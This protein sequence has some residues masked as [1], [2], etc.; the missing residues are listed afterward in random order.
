MKVFTS[1]RLMCDQQ[2]FL[3]GG[4]W[5]AAS[6]ARP[7]CLFR[8][9]SI[10]AIC[11]SKGKTEGASRWGRHP[12]FFYLSLGVGRGGRARYRLQDVIHAIFLQLVHEAPQMPH[13]G[14]L[15]AVVPKEASDV[16][17]AL[18]EPNRA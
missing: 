17:Y 15:G 4:G 6:R 11:A 3:A 12:R 1:S 10:F 5:K 7:V 9:Q 16:V 2:P 13:D 14:L 8:C 18:L